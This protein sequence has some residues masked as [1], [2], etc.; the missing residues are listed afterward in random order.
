MSPI[1]LPRWISPWVHMRNFSPVSE[2]RKGKRF[3]G[4]DLAANSRNKANMAK[5]KNFGFRAHHNF[6]NSE[7]CITAVNW[8]LMTVKYSRQCKLRRCHPDRHNSSCFHPG[9][10]AEVFI[11][12]DFQSAYRDLG[13]KNR[14]LGKRTSP[15][16]HMNT[17]KILQRI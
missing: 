9:N 12:Q 16:S 11:W 13:W 8:I 6:G 4:R 2:M 17:S 3:W 5:H 1:W 14:D 15:P 7:S 10:W